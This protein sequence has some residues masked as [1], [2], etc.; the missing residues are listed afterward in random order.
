MPYE[1]I[2]NR[3]PAGYS[4]SS[5]RDGEKVGISYREFVSFEDGETFIRR[6]EGFPSELLKKVPDQTIK[7]GSVDHIFAVIEKSGHCQLFV[8]EC[9]IVGKTQVRRSV[10]KGEPVYESDIIDYEEIVFEGVKVPENAGVAVV[11]S[12]GWRKGFYYDFGPLQ[13]EPISRDYDVWKALGACYTYLTFQEYFRVTDQEYR[14][15]FDRSW[16]P[17]IGL[18]KAT[19]LKLL[20]YLRSGWNPDDL[21]DEIAN[22]VR[23]N[24]D[25]MLDRW[26]NHPVLAEHS[27]LLQTACERFSS[28]DY[29]SCSGLIYPRIEGI[30]R[31]IARNAGSGYKQK[32]LAKV[33]NQQSARASISRVLPE[34][35]VEY[36]EEVYFRNFDPELPDHVSRNTMGHGVAP[37]EMYDEK[38]ATI[39]LLVVD[40]IYLHLPSSSSKV[41]E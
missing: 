7:P 38:A 31:T 33:A 30:L 6:L 36:L 9:N 40:Q 5:G 18:N 16:F 10:Q 29:V 20:N 27:G 2:L 14:V 12:V 17:F 23:T 21:A 8:N 24:V 25:N 35:F 19:I 26:K 41:R 28:R 3:P 32:Q 13:S 1:F 34:R 22:E 4:L 37:Q 39:G 15:L 11:F